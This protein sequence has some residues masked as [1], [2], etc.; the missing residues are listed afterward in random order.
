MRT[1]SQEVTRVALEVGTQDIL[2]GL[3]R[4][5]G[6]EG[7]WAHLTENVNVSTY[8][9]SYRLLVHLMYITANCHQSDQSSEVHRIR[10][11]SGR[12]W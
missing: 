6:V 2:G 8:L 11:Q 7:T 5:E 3:A 9:F 10:Y 1:F 4:F 12:C